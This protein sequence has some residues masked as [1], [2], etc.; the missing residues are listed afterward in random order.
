LK[1]RRHARRGPPRVGVGL[2]AGIRHHGNREKSRPSGSMRR[3]AGVPALAS[4]AGSTSSVRCSELATCAT[5]AHADRP[6]RPPTML[7]SPSARTKCIS[8]EQMSSCH[9]GCSSPSPP[10][11]PPRCHGRCDA[12][13]RGIVAACP[14]KEEE[15]G[16]CTQPP[17][18]PARDM[19]GRA[20]RLHALAHAGVGTRVRPAGQR[21]CAGAHQR[22]AMAHL[23]T[24]Y[25]S[26]AA[27]AGGG[28]PLS[29]AGHG[30]G[31]VSRSATSSA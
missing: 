22:T 14:A 11:P 30:H 8:S 15:A 1:S 6:G 7:P 29:S 24:S 16:T 18:P 4:S 19:K 27:H 13:L 12:G 17:P 3:R 28:C 5:A 31:Y 23:E 26:D 20:E 2:V 10:P 21:C 25:Q 9:S